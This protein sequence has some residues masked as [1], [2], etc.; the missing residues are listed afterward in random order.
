[1]GRGKNLLDVAMSS[2]LQATREEEAA[3][4]EANAGGFVIVNTRL[5]PRASSIAPRDTINGLG[6]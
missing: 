2:E 1:M 6:F 5:N 4:A 3:A